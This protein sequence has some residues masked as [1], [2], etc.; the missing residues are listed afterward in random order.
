MQIENVRP[1]VG[2]EP[3]ALALGGPRATIAPARHWYDM[4]KSLQ[5]KTYILKQKPEK[6]EGILFLRIRIVEW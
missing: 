6:R 1:N 2:L 5:S 3:T 4:L